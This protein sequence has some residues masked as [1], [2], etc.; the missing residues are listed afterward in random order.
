MRA[1]T[2]FVFV[3]AAVLVAACR[4][5]TSPETPQHDYPWP[6]QL[7]DIGGTKLAYAEMGSGPHTLVLVH[8]LGSYMPA[9]THNVDALASRYRVIAVDLPGY[10]KSDK[11]DAPYSMKY[12]AR[13][14]RALLDELGV[15]QPVLVGHSMG[16]QIAMTYALMYPN[17][18]AGL[19]L[20]SPAGLETFGDAEATWMA[21]S[22]TPAFT[23]GADDEAIYTRHVQ[24]F[25]AMPKDAEVMIDDRIAM[26]DDPDFPD[27]CRAV[28]RSVAGML[29]QP[30]HD[31]IPEIAGPVL[32]LFGKSDALIPNP[33]LHG[34]STARLAQREVEAF[35]D[36]ELV[37]LDKAGH[38]AQFEAHERWNAAVL[39]FVATLPS[40]PRPTRAAPPERAAPVKKAQSEPASS[41]E[42]APP[43]DE[44][45]AEPEPEPAPA[46]V[47]DETA[48]A[49]GITTEADAPA[50]E[51][52]APAEAP[53]P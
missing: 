45:L 37:L 30:V 43:V 20:T 4:P 51:A 46:T 17:G 29:D 50:P 35:P 18:Y 42:P 13:S 36:A 27:Y 48:E 28:S 33:F 9:W 19:V 22:V 41:P 52:P 23:C 2:R 24:N 7:A 8:G 49:D 32:V 6:V 40:G 5:A 12:F 3:L 47:A 34:G 26:R 31:Q 16:G 44:P 10:G 53:V 1:V 11:P 14:L 25:H 21:N 38:M 39:D 15:T